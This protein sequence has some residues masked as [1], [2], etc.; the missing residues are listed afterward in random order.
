MSEI[1]KTNQEKGSLLVWVTNPAAAG[2][3]VARAKHFA[4]EKGLELKVVSVQ[5]ET[6]GNW[7]D[8]IRDLERLK[9][10][11]TKS[12]A[13][14]TVVYS[15]DRIEAALKLAESENPRAMFTGVPEKGS[16]SA[17]A[18]ALYVRF[19]SVTLYCVDTKGE[20]NEYD[21]I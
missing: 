3:I 9:E 4:S 16:A 6:R 8:T 15:D 14:L 11:A 2:R 7:E 10:A 19:P 13:E 1:D 12:D 5:R 17:F 21:K 20:V 18:D